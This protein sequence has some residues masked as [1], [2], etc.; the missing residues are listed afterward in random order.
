MVAVIFR[1]CVITAGPRLGCRA[2]ESRA[3]HVI[4]RARFTCACI[5]V[6]LVCHRQCMEFTVWYFPSVF[7]DRR[8]KI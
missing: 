1:A 4:N 5:A 8:L 7:R 6:T 3:N 2:A